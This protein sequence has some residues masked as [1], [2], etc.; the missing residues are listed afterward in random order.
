MAQY[1]RF[2]RSR[3]LK[4]RTKTVFYAFALLQTIAH[5]IFFI[6]AVLSANSLL[7]FFFESARPIVFRGGVDSDRF[8]LGCQLSE[9]PESREADIPDYVSGEMGGHR[10]GGS[11][12]YLPGGT[13]DLVLCS[14]LYCQR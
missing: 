3:S 5:S 9:I 11:N 13:H 6:A 10:S 7:L 12:T 2:K 4:I 14:I 8:L 1:I